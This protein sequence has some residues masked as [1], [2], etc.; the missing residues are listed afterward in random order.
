MEK[1]SPKK[2]RTSVRIKAAN[3]LGLMVLAVA[4]FASPLTTFA[5]GHA[6]HVGLPG[7]SRLPVN[8]RRLQRSL[9]ND[10]NNGDNSNNNDNIGDNSNNNNGCDSFPFDPTQLL[11]FLR[12]VC[13][14]IG[15]DPSDNNDPSNS[16]SPFD[17]TAF[18]Q[19]LLKFLQGIHGDIG[20]DPNNNND[21]S[22]SSSP[23]DA[24]A[25]QQQLL[26][27]L[28]GICTD[29]GNNNCDPTDGNATKRNSIANA[30]KVPSQDAFTILGVF[31][32]SGQPFGS[33]PSSQT[34]NSSPIA[35]VKVRSLKDIQKGF[36]ITAKDAKGNTFTG[37][38]I[39]PSPSP[40][41]QAIGL[42]NGQGKPQI[43]TL[44]L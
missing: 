34:R 37:E 18:Q 36:F 38:V 24:T 29:I 13:G 31:E 23:F 21:P 4:F 3:V 35:L 1:K 43:V 6:N 39:S 9:Q 8:S 28:Q 33:K 15:N 20:N 42:I 41:K 12:G 26:K 32:Q 11:K 27:F 19:Q 10:N 16:S 14:N 44:T 25:F 5:H 30:S 22:D 7:P 17:A 40:T 2:P